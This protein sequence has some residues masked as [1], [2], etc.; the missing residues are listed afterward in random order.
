MGSTF[1][2]NGFDLYDDDVGHNQEVLLSLALIRSR[3]AP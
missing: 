2:F 3:P 1:D